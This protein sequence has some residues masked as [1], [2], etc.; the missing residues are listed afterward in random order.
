MVQA[1]CGNRKTGGGLAEPDR[2]AALRAALRGTGD[3]GPLRDRLHPMRRRPFAR[4]Q[5]ASMMTCRRISP[6]AATG[7]YHRMTARISPA[8][9][10]VS[11][12]NSRREAQRVWCCS[13][14]RISPCETRI[15]AGRWRLPAMQPRRARRCGRDNRHRWRGMLICRRRGCCNR[16]FCVAGNSRRQTSA[17][18]SRSCWRDGGMVGM[19]HRDHST[20]GA[21]S[22]S[23][24]PTRHS[25]RP[26][27]FLSLSAVR[28]R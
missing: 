12:N 11:M 2:P 17:D 27:L 26:G 13:P 19:G 9:R 10:R 18:L 28:S 15:A 1:A 16:N 6:S 3:R 23:Q 8:S 21:R 5:L 4:R 22:L 24:H 25:Q 14:M 20:T 7:C